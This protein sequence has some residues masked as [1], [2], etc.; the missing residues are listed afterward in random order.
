MGDGRA[1]GGNS[2]TF[3]LVTEAFLSDRL[4]WRSGQACCRGISA[5]R[6][7]PQAGLKLLEAQ[8]VEAAEVHYPIISCSMRI[9]PYQS[10]LSGLKTV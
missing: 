10:P 7:V 6:P 3:E 9:S 4:H 1:P 5:S 8:V 2:E